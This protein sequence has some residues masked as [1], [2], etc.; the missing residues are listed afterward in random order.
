MGQRS[1]GRSRARCALA[2]AGALAAMVASAQV[3]PD[4]GRIQEQLRSPELPKQPA[5]PQIRIEPAPGEAKADTPAFYVASFRVS[6]ATVFPEQRLVALLGEPRRPMRLAEVQA[7]ADRITELYRSQGYIVARA[8]IPA[9]DVRDGIVEVRVVE[10]RYERIDISNASD[11]SERRLRGLL[12]DVRE[13]AVV[14][15]PTLERAV[16]LIADLAG[17]QP[18]A[19]LEAGT[20]PG[21]TNLILELVPTPSAQYDLTVDNAG[22]R[23]TG[24]NRLS[25]GVTLN[26]P[27]GI[28]DRLS[29]RAVTSGAN[30]NSVQVSY[31]APLGYSSVRGGAYATDTTY[32]LG[33]QFT[34]LDASGSARSYGAMVVYPALR[35]AELNLRAQAAA[36]RRELVDRIGAFGT[37][38]DK[39]MTLVRW[40][41]SGDTRDDLLAGGLTAFQALLTQG[42]LAL[43]SPDFAAS[44]AATARTQGDFRKLSLAANRLQGLTE[45]LRLIVTYTGQLARDNLDSS[46]KFSVGGIT[47]VRAYPPGEAAGDDVHLLQAELRYSAGNWR[48]GRVTPSL[49]A[50]H[51]HSRINHQLWEGFNGKNVRRLSDFGVGMEWAIPGVWFVRGWYAHKLGGEPATAERDKAARLWLQAGVLF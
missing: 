8:L 21:F 16:L 6:G 11:L 29:A 32:K 40:G 4:A 44:D 9:Q 37:T 41:G 20:Q 46:E 28:G 26:S 25:A 31:D 35:S 14:H 42:T 47:G 5:A 38:N 39:T 27:L 22:S 12:G 2:L 3:P 33:D 18:K 48:G 23:Y 24:R 50:D 45:R 43:H 10:G 51:A 15:G 7:L 30:L 19:T 13:D 34:T 49:F 17:V 1:T 36:E